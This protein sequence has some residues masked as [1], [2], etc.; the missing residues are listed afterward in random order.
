[1]WE[2]QVAVN[3]RTIAYNDMCFWPGLVGGFHLPVTVVPI[4]F[5]KS[6]LPIGMQISGPI[7]GDRTTLMAASLFEQAGFTF[8]PPTLEA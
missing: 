6:G 2:R 4:G 5:T 3:E 8:R 7:Y 1:V